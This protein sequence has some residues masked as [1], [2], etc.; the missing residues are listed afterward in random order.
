MSLVDQCPELSSP[1]SEAQAWHS[2][3][4]PRPCQPHG[5][6]EVCGLLPASSMCSVGAVPQVNVSEVFVGRK[7]I[8]TSYSSAILKVS[9]PP[10]NW[11]SVLHGL[12][13]GV[14]WMAGSSWKVSSEFLYISVFP[15]SQSPRPY[16]LNWIELVLLW[17]GWGHSLRKNV[18]HWRKNVTPVIFITPLS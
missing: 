12:H 10:K 7:V 16:T 14:A 5:F 13:E 15:S 1:T 17:R 18:K 6:W 11:K 4:A 3:G 9:F 8:S 2:A